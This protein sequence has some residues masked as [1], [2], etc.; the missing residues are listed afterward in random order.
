MYRIIRYDVNPLSELPEH[1]VTGPPV[2]RV[3]WIE[4]YKGLKH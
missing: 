4:P 2:Q 1:L 3:A